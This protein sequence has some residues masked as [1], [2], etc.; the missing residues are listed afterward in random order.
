[1]VTEN[2]F[3]NKRK[4]ISLSVLK[5]KLFFNL[6]HFLIGII[7]KSYCSN[8]KSIEFNMHN[9]SFEDFPHFTFHLNPQHFLLIHQL[10][11]LLYLKLFKFCF[12]INVKFKKSLKKSNILKYELYL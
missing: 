7:F 3:L 6:S 5:F 11:V 1:M 4:L 2:R 12:L 9:I 10:I 8:C